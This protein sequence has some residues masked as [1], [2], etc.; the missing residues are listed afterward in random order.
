[1]LFQTVVVD[2]SQNNYM[3]PVL[4]QP[5]LALYV[6]SLEH[7]SKPAMEPLSPV[8]NPVVLN[9]QARPLADY[10][11]DVVGVQLRSMSLIRINTD[12]LVSLF[13]NETLQK[14]L[15]EIMTF[16]LEVDY[17]AAMTSRGKAPTGRDLALFRM[18]QLHRIWPRLE[19]LK[20]NFWPGWDPTYRDSF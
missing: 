15:A 2:P 7:H 16:A 12:D 9:T 13:R 17:Q 10:A 5:H 1:M 14:I 19:S 3:T 4:Q 11:A 6:R 20:L 18:T 8:S